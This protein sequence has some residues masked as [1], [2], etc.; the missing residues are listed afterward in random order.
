VSS[1]Q[2]S[3]SPTQTTSSSCGCGPRS[4]ACRCCSGSG[5]VNALALVFAVLIAAILQ[6]AAFAKL[7]SADPRK[8]V[9]GTDTLAEKASWLSR[10]I[11]EGHFIGAMELAIVVLILAFYRWRHTWTLLAIFFLSMAGF[12][13]YAF[14]N[15]R[16]C[17]CFGNVITLPKGFTIGM[18]AGIAALAMLMM[19]MKGLRVKGL[20]VALIVG[21]IGF[22][23]GWF[24]GSKSEW[25]SADKFQPSLEIRATTPSPKAPT[26]D[27]SDA[28]DPGAGPG[29]PASPTT[30]GS[31]SKSDQPAAADTART[32]EYYLEVD[33]AAIAVGGKAIDVTMAAR[34]LVASN[35]LS[36]ERSDEWGVACYVF[37]HDPACH[38]CEEL[39]PIVFDAKQR[40]ADEEN[41]L[42]QV[43]EFT[44][45]FL[46][47][48]LKIDFWA[49]NGTPTVLV[50]KDGAIVYEADGKTVAL[51]KDIEEMLQAGDLD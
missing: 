43:R 12:A 20:A 7:I 38:V 19:W 32:P 1:Q 51:P 47:Q 46:Q 10:P 49:W 26:T 28:S 50:I 39:K 24:Y 37:V 36:A 14:V 40:Y 34:T 42:I 11:V 25:P 41:P 27:A 21:A 4:A 8:I 3:T 23:G 9:P 15:G 16:N 29:D 6:F 33:P 18:D 45:P 44:V 35:L 13:T 22:G 48:H 17:G 31:T 30:D 2:P 5:A